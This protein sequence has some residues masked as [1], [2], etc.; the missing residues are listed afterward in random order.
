[1]RSGLDTHSEPALSDLLTVFCER[2][3]ECALGRPDT[4]WTLRCAV[5]SVPA[6]DG[7]SAQS[8]PLTPKTFFLATHSALFC[9]STRELLLFL[10]G[11]LTWFKH[12]APVTIHLIYVI[13][14]TVVSLGCIPTVRL[15][16][17]V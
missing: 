6:C 16:W 3:R 17:Q 9:N 12:G 7:E 14:L 5:Q 11:P 13:S 8:Q 1:M 15:I 4:A 10:E 2:S